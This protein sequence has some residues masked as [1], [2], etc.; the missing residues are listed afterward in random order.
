M[1]KGPTRSI[2]KSKGLIHMAPLVMV[3]LLCVLY[4]IFT[5]P[6]PKPKV[7]AV[8][9]Q[10][11]IGPPPC[12]VGIDEEMAKAKKLL[13][14]QKPVEAY[15][16][17]FSCRDAHA[18]GPDAATYN[19]A[20]T[21]WQKAKDAEEKRARLAELARKKREGVSI[22]MSRQDVLES[23][24]GKPDNINSTTRASGTREQWVYR[25]NSRGYL[26]FENGVLTS[27]QH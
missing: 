26:Y 27:I 8:A 16:V 9:V 12:T 14:A 7:Q 24:W 3:A 17:L 18:A 1:P 23:S 4:A 2:G 20:M 13:A 5:A 22:G 15:D 10:A 19:K 21:Q 11:P 6:G 25:S